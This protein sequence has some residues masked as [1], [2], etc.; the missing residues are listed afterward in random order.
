MSNAYSEAIKAF[1]PISTADAEKHL[2]LEELTIIYIGRENCPYCRKFV[3]KLSKLAPKIAAPIYYIDSIA[4][5]N[6]EAFREEYRIVT[7]PGFIV[8]KEGELDVRCDSSMPEEEILA[9][10]Q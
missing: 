9:M 4:D 5:P 10:V 3:D 7:V 2:A 6:I 1:H 8:N